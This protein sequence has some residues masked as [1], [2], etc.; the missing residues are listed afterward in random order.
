MAL[1]KKLRLESDQWTLW[2]LNTLWNW[3]H[4]WRR[5]N[6]CRR[7][8]RL[9]WASL[10]H[11]FIGSSTI[12]PYSMGTPTSPPISRNWGARS[13]ES[14]ASIQSPPSLVLAAHSGMDIKLLTEKELQKKRAKGFC[15]RCDAKWAV[16][17]RCKIKELSMMSI[18]E[19]DGEHIL[20]R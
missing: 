5:N 9:G 7:I 2:I 1:R 15:Y 20:R 19:E 18:A 13:P 4:V 17:H 10:K 14:Q 6:V 16:G 8:R 3:L 11:E 12:G